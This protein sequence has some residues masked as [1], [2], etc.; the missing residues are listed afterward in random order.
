MDRKN[1]EAHPPFD[2]PPQ[3]PTRPTTAFPLEDRD[4]LDIDRLLR[5]IHVQDAPVVQIDIESEDDFPAR[6]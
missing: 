2:G 4:D 6:S 1:I 3:L 5:P